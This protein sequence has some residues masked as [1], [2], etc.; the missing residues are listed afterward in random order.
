[1]DPQ[2]KYN[3]RVSNLDRDKKF[4]YNRS[5]KLS[6]AVGDWT[7]LQFRDPELEDV[8]ISQIRNVNFD[9]FPRSEMKKLHYLHYRIAEK[10]VK[11]FSIDMDVK[12][13]L[14]TVMASQMTYEDFVKSQK[15][16]TLQSDF[17][18]KGIGNVNFLV[19]QD[20]ANIMIN[21]LTGGTG[22]TEKKETFTPIEV[23][24]LQTQ[25][26]LL[27]LPFTKAWKNIFSNS[28]VS[29]RCNFGMCN[30]DPKI[31]KREAHLSFTFYMN[32]GNSDLQMVT[33]AY[34]SSLIR[35]LLKIKSGIQQA[36]I[37]Q[38]VFFDK[39]TQKKEQVEI[40]AI[41]GKAKLKMSELRKL[42]I[43][44]IIPLDA[45]FKFPID[46]TIGNKCFFKAQPGVVD[47]KLCI[48]L[49]N[50]QKVTNPI[51]RTV[52]SYS[53]DSEKKDE[54]VKVTD[55]EQQPLDQFDDLSLETDDDFND[56]DVDDWDSFDD[57]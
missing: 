15:T 41:L 55:N 54:D 44:D 38:R 29:L 31:S 47:N 24:I 11:Q 8:H 7:T 17:I 18:I 2:L 19:G 49:L 28:D 16:P 5:L 32:F 22:K 39:R 48:Q 20:L 42:E 13:E 23:S 12:V 56:E 33:C 40:K 10:L 35:R 45:Q 14:H 37:K 53:E 6:P 51:I 25:M 50:P 26:E 27:K 36:P 46:V 21:R 4:L 34:P 9:S 3:L 43:G 30:F 1:M 57:E 52:G